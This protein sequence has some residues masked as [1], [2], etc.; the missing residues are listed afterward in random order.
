MKKFSVSCIVFFFVCIAVKAQNPAIGNVGPNTVTYENKSYTVR[1]GTITDDGRG[2]VVVEILTAEKIEIPMKNGAYVAPIMMKIEAGG[3]TLVASD[4]VS[5]LDYSMSFNF[6]E[7]P[8]QVMVYGNDGNDNC[9][10]VTF[11]I[12]KDMVKTPV[13]SVTTVP[14]SRP[15][16]Q[17]QPV[18][19]PSRP[20]TYQEQ[21]VAQQTQTVQPDVNFV[22]QAKPLTS[23]EKWRRWYLEFGLSIGILSPDPTSGSSTKYP[24]KTMVHAGAAI[25]IGFYIHPRHRLSFDIGVGGN[26]RKIDDVVNRE[27]TSSSVLLSYHYV[28][29]PSDKCHIR[30]GPS[31]GAISLLATN[32]IDQLDVNNTF[33][34]DEDETSMTV[35]GIGVGCIWKLGERWFIDSG[36]RLMAGGGMELD[37]F[38]I[39][40][41]AHQFNLTIGWRF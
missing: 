29:T 10:T 16:H 11:Q 28:F 40:S 4:Q 32:N 15:A 6:G 26:T 30:L 8:D 25:D 14:P 33:D 24:V 13:S 35:F 5:I 3:K 1:L 36:Y 2:T 9:P 12:T 39:S 38:E 22:Q 20:E 41:P 37:G 31:F 19:P 17:E 27:Y 21:P 7:I 18:A 34:K 23:D